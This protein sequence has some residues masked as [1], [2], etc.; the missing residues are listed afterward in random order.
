MGIANLFEIF[1]HFSLLTPYTDVQS[2]LHFKKTRHSLDC[3]KKGSQLCPEADSSKR[4]WACVTS[5]LAH[6]SFNRQSTRV[7]STLANFGFKRQPARVTSTLAY[8]GLKEL[9]LL[10]T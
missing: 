1:Y 6:F 8:F 2:T 9:A 5:T 7:T 4:Q 10:P 3:W